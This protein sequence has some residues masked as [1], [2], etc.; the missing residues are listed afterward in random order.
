MGP[1]ED[2]YV[3]EVVSPGGINAVLEEWI[4]FEKKV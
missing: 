3:M 2:S 1:S 4:N